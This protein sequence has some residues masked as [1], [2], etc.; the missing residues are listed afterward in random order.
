MKKMRHSQ[1]LLIMDILDHG[2]D[3]LKREM[4]CVKLR[5]EKKAGILREK[6]AKLLECSDAD[7]AYFADE[8]DKSNFH[9]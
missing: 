3:L 2:D 4:F 7:L 5:K 9:Y 6:R 1:L 8:L